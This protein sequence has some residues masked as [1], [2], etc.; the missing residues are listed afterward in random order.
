MDEDQD[1]SQKPQGWFAT[2]HWSVVLEAR[3]S[4]S[5]RTR[6]ALESLCRTYWP[7][8]F[9]YVRGKGYSEHD[10]QDLVQEYI[11]RLLEKNYLDE[12][13]RKRK[14]ECRCQI[15][16]RSSWCQQP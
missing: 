2:T 11:S 7:P 15:L 10:A 13:D 4:G 8:L 5:L 9:A 14:R 1:T 16:D 12:V 6:E 3:K